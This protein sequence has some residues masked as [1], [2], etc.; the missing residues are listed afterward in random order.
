MLTLLR[1]HGVML[2]SAK[3]PVPNVAD[4]IAGERIRGS[5][6][7]HSR[8]KRIFAALNALQD[9][10]DVLTCRIVDGKRSF[11]H[12]RLWPALVRCAGRFPADWLA[13]ARE[14]HTPSGKHV[15][16]DL[17]FPDWVPPDVRDVA[18]ALSEDEALHAL[19]DWA[20]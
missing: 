17:P 5:W 10:D 11:V 16:I 14:V 4:A 18:A 1:E 13:S 20:R 2:A 7:G 19:G 9:S 3:G 12:R 8:G 6:W 15:R